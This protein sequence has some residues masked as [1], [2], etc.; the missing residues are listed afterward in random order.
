MIKNIQDV[1]SCLPE[2]LRNDPKKAVVLT[3]LLLVLL[4]L[5]V[6][7]FGF[8]SSPAKA[9]AKSAAATESESLDNA[10]G[11]L[12]VVRVAKSEKLEQWLQTPASPVL[13][14]VF[15]FHPEFFPR[16]ETAKRLEQARPND[17][18][19]WDRLA[20][21]VAARA[22]QK[23]QKQIRLENLRASAAKLKL[24]S[25]LMSS[26]P[27]AL[28]E[29]RLVRI[30]DSLKSTDGMAFKVIAIEARRI[31]VEREGVMVQIPMGSD[32]KVKVVSSV[33]P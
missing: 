19:F 26:H 21:S 23:M 18:L 27:R 24:Q 29:G 6:R 9:K 22:D 25:T 30:G 11:D 33:G 10:I 1:M 20:K 3:G 14:N 31:V 28:V 2:P 16:A 8:S 32:E 7:Q 4:G 5:G 15:Q 13:R 12:S 17:L